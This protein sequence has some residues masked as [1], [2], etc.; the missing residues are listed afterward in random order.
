M[1]GIFV[2]VFV[3]V[4][5]G[6]CCSCVWHTLLYSWVLWFGFAIFIYGYLVTRKKD[7]GVDGV[8]GPELFVVGVRVLQR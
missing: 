8:L 3:S 7:S 4:G 6:G 5:V 2:D 1:R